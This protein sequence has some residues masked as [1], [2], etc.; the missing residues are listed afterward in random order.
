MCDEWMKLE[1][2]MGHL[3]LVKGQIR[4]I[5]ILCIW[6]YGYN[7]PKWMIIDKY[8]QVPIHLWSLITI[9]LYFFFYLRAEEF[10]QMYEIVEN[11]DNDRKKSPYICRYF[12][13][14]S[15][16]LGHRTSVGFESRKLI[17]LSFPNKFRY[18]NRPNKQS[19][20]HFI[21]AHA[22]ILFVIRI[23]CAMRY[24]WIYWNR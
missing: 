14:E 8:L 11:D 7:P 24:W 22:L 16:S 17:R 6:C 15:L 13:P 9:T 3:W 2:W 18:A 21:P 1:P 4:I 20:D 5:S 23:D 19:R 10:L 12:D